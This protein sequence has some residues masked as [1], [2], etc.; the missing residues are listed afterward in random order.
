MHELEALWIFLVEVDAGNTAI[1]DLTPE[2][3]EIGAALVPYPCFWEEA[4]TAACFEYTD[5]KIYI[6]SETHGRKAIQS[7][8]NIL[9]DTH[10]E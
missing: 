2:F 9:A 7:E 6:L 5:R 1:I 8:I 4:A 10:I 3:T